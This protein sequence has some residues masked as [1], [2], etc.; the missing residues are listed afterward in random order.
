[1]SPFLKKLRHE[2]RMKQ[3]PLSLSTE[4][5]KLGQTSTDFQVKWGKLASIM[6]IDDS[7]SGNDAPY[8]VSFA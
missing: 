6:E 8:L 7:L 5:S 3:F 4:A 1:V 2:A